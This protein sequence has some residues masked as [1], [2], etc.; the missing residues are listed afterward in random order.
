MVWCAGGGALGEIGAA[1]SH[2]ADSFWAAEDWAAKK[3]KDPLGWGGQGSGA[4]AHRCGSAGDACSCRRSA[5][6]RVE[7]RTF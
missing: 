6:V 1:A 4:G 2:M 3:L 7:E 5:G